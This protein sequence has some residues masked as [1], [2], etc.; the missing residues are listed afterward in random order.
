MNPFLDEI[1]LNKVRTDIQ[2]RSLVP[3]RGPGPTHG[4]RLSVELNAEKADTCLKLL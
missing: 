3:K 1:L 4:H 2:A